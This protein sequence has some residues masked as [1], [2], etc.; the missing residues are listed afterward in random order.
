MMKLI[1]WNGLHEKGIHYSKPHLWRLI[2]AGKFPPPVKIGHKNAW[3]E[4]EI[5]ELIRSRIAD[6]DFVSRVA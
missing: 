6:R 3:P 2:R 1:D 5:D 4:G